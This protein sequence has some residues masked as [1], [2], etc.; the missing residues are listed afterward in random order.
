MQAILSRFIPATNFKGSRIKATCGRGSITVDYSHEGNCEE[1]HILAVDALIA[2]FVGED[3]IRYGSERNPWSKP[4]VC[5]QLPDGD[6]AHVFVHD[7]NLVG[8]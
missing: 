6:Y 2:R 8:A 4:R 5:G 7:S 1:A 3:A